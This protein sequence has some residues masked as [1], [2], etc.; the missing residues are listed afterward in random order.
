MF[1][2]FIPFLIGAMPAVLRYDGSK[3]DFIELFILAFRKSLNIS[4][5]LLIVLVRMSFSGGDQF[6]PSPS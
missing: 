6:D 4:E 2:V 5:L 1:R 3:K